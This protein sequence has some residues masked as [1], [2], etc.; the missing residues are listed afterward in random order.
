[1]IETTT[2]LA[3]RLDRPGQSCSGKV[4]AVLPHTPAAAKLIDVARGYCYASRPVCD[5]I[6]M[7]ELAP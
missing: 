3:A 6:R 7:P 1:M 5:R 2:E 4:L